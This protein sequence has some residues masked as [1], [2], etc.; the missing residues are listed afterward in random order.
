MKGSKI[1]EI[2]STANDF[3]FQ[4]ILPTAFDEAGLRMLD[5]IREIFDILTLEF[6]SVGFE[7]VRYRKFEEI[8]NAI[9]DGKCPIVDVLKKYL[10]K[11]FMR[12]WML[13]LR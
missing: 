10:S 1:I 3:A 12:A 6:E 11:K 5:S 4:L 8:V 7:F 13:I 2:R 9:D